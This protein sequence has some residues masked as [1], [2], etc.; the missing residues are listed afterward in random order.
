MAPAFRCVW[1]EL[2]Q[3]E[4][5]GESNPKNRSILYEELKFSMDEAEKIKVNL[6]SAAETEGFQVGEEVLDDDQEQG[7]RNTNASIFNF[8]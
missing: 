3:Y 8:S 5:V 2:P 6:D 4:E 7:R 1:R